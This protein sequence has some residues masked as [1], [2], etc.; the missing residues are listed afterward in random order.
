MA[1][2]RTILRAAALVILS[3]STALDAEAARRSRKKARAP[4]RPD[5][6]LYQEATAARAAFKKSRARQARRGEWEAVALK[7]RRVVDRYPKSSWCDNAL[8]DAGNL[9]REAAERFDSARYRN[10][11]LKAYR[12]IVAEYPSSRLGEPALYAV[13]ELTRNSGPKDKAGEAARGYLAAYPRGPHA[14]ALRTSLKKREPAQAMDLPEPPPPGTVEI[15]DLRQWGG[16][17][18]VRVVLDLEKAVEVGHARVS[19][20][21]DRVVVA[22]SGARLHPN[23]VSRE[24]H[25]EDGLLRAVRLVSRSPKDVDLVLDFWA[26]DT[27]TVFYLQAPP[28][29]VIDAQGQPPLVAAASVPRPAP[30]L[31]ATP[32]R[33]IDSYVGRLRQSTASGTDSGE[34]TVVT[35]DTQHRPLATQPPAPTASPAVGVIDRRKNPVN[36]K[37][38]KNDEPRKAEPDPEPVPGPRDK[39]VESTPKNDE[40]GTPVAEFSDLEPDIPPPATPAP[41]TPPKTNRGGSYSLARQLGLTARRIVIDPGHGGHDPGTIG[42]GGLQEKDLVLDIALRLERL[43]S[44]ELGVEVVMTRDKDVFIP[45]EERTAIANAKEAD[46]FL[47]IH[48]NSSRSRKAR[49]IETYYLNFAGTP[50]AE[51]VAAR[52]NAV[53]SGTMNDLQGLVK[54]IMLNSKIPESRDFAAAVQESLV[55]HAR[56]VDSGTRDRGVHTAPFYVLIGATMPSV[57][58]EIA[59]VSHPDEEKLLKKSAYRDTI[60]RSLLGGVRSY[61]ATLP[62]GAI[63]TGSARRTDPPARSRP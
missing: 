44:D 6:A 5:T 9:Y 26:L 45:L 31:P 43:L 37:N 33:G 28:R 7:F 16:D 59:F 63:M 13:Y 20:E 10:E 23:L 17:A 41:S 3:L 60:A 53:S 24:V 32:P 1:K 52:E 29:L 49:G 39:V 8:L 25:R 22:L 14:A 15:F 35:S 55:R 40:H 54:A 57:L 21:L 11:A 18:S 27:Y 62:Q 48:A 47:S 36:L 4:A 56:G 58:A 12:W 30:S 38:E 51:A 34:E 2:V 61:L 42:N 50:H 19:S 46:L